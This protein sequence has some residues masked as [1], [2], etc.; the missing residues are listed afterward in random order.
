MPRRSSPGQPKV[1][2]RPTASE[3]ARRQKSRKMQAETIDSEPLVREKPSTSAKQDALAPGHSGDVNDIGNDTT[4]TKLTIDEYKE[5][6]QPSGFQVTKEQSDF[7]SD[8]EM[9]DLNEVQGNI[10]V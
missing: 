8:T 3:R 1:P 10:I 2:R 7:Q 6:L 4:T 5:K 9:E